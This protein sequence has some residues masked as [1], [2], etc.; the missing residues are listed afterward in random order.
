LRFCAEW[1]TLRGLLL[2]LFHSA[3]R[4]QYP[5]RGTS[6]VKLS[7]SLASGNGHR[8]NSCSIRCTSFRLPLTV[9]GSETC[10]AAKMASAQANAAS[11]S[12]KEP[13]RLP[14]DVILKKAGKRAIGGG[15]P[16]AV[17]M[18]TQVVTLMPLRTTMNVS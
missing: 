2:N 11:A 13:E 12:K 9:D 18:A 3:G 8:N 7:Y 1:S 14:I 16:G 4:E 6:C 17:A 5:F 10:R 15:V